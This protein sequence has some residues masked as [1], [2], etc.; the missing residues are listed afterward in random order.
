MTDNETTT[1]VEEENKDGAPEENSEDLLSLDNLDSIL[2]EEDPEFAKAL[3]EIG[4]DEEIDVDLS[5]ESLGL[6]YTL[7]DE[8]KLWA[9]KRPKLA[10]FFPFLPK[11]SYKVKMKR[12]SLRL[13][14][15]KF[16]EQSIYNI[17]NAGPLLL[18]WLKNRIQSMKS[19]VGEGLAAFSTFSLVKKLA[20]VGLLGATGASGYVIYKLATH[21]LL[22]PDSEL[23][24]SSLED[25]AQAKYQY[26][27]ED[28]MESFYDST[29]T[30][31]SVLELKKFVVNLRRSG[32]S[33][34]NPMGAFEFYV[35]GTVSEAVVEIKDR[36]SE[37]RDLFL[38]TIEDMTYDQMASAEGKRL[39]CDR[40]RKELNKV[41]TKGKVRRIFFKTAI[42]KP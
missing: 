2:A 19:S 33:G 4:P 27:S 26:S 36:E 35:E 41:L 31:Q 22:P 18:G 32:T 24:I 21:K 7:E 17:R 16:K 20:F 37:I 28:Q 30:S 10:K 42:V 11:I 15:T 3:S 13:S 34:P 8:V 12:T 6:E 23:F 25:W 38:R 40:L 9:D 39:L 29:R 5:N 14:W 1:K